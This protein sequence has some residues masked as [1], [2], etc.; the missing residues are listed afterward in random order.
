MLGADATD[1]FILNLVINIS[2]SGLFGYL[3][4]R[5][6]DFGRR[7][8]GVLAGCPQA[9]DLPLESYTGGNKAGGSLA[10]AVRSA[11]RLDALIR[12]ADVIVVA[13]RARDVVDAVLEYKATA[14]KESEDVAL[15]AC[16]IDGGEL[17]T[18]ELGGDSLAV[19][20]AAVDIDSETETTR[21]WIDW[22]DRVERSRREVTIFRIPR[23]DPGRGMGDAY[24]V[25][26]GLPKKIDLAGH[27]S[28][29]APQAR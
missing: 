9:R 24:S 21:A 14:E 26:V 7:S 28:G 8:L 25:A 10:R 6:L 12:V 11:T 5:E 16:A 19:S 1:V 13:G 15:V 22:V 29:S 23:R 4:K 17:D 3:A 18:S 27:I 20:A 2:A